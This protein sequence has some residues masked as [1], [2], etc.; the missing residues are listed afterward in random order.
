MLEP[1]ASADLLSRLAAAGTQLRLLLGA[2]AYD[3]SL[4]AHRHPLHAVPTRTDP[5]WVWRASWHVLAATR[6]AAGL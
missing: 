1:S 5:A 2:K 4:L 6:A 3:D